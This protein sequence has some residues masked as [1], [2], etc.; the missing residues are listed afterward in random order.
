MNETAVMLWEALELKPTA[1]GVELDLKPFI[2][3][4]FGRMKNQLS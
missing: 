1:F 2:T 4:R 3:R